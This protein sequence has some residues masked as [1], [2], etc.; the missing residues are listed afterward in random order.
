[1]VKIDRSQWPIVYIEVDA[2]TTLGDMEEYNA[3]MDELLDYAEQQP[4][5]Y[6]IVYLYQGTEEGHK[7]FKREKD[8]QKLSNQWL[9]ANKSRIGERCVAIAMVTQA[10]GLMKMMW[11]IARMSMKRMMGAP[12]DMFFTKEEADQ[13][14]TERMSH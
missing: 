3:E 12:G 8:A 7:S 6:G 13:W 11:P 1:M 4:E 9:K 14:M 10:K 5:K 2:L